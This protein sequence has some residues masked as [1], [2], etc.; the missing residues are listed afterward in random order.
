[1]TRLSALKRFRDRQKRKFVPSVT[2]SLFLVLVS[3]AVLGRMFS[4]EFIVTKICDAEYFRGGAP[5]N[6]TVAPVEWFIV[7]AILAL[8]T[9]LVHALTGLIRHDFRWLDLTLGSV[10]FLLAFGLIV[11]W[12]AVWSIWHPFHPATRVLD[13]YSLSLPIL[14]TKPIDLGVSEFRTFFGNPKWE[15]LDIRQ[16]GE[17]VY[18]HRTTGVIMAREKV[19][20]CQPDWVRQANFERLKKAGRWDPEDSTEG[21]SDDWYDWVYRDSENRIIYAPASK[22]DPAGRALLKEFENNPSPIT[23]DEFFDMLWREEEARTPRRSARE[24]ANI[25]YDEFM[26]RY[27]RKMERKA[28]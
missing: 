26:E 27:M 2:L 8:L 6:A 19:H 23:K 3:F 18:R 12:V 15:P 14:P 24:R 13:R 7:I 1:M 16:N 17:P 9:Q 4:L 20:S 25:S 28:R 5:S 21:F 10:N 11:Y 22:S